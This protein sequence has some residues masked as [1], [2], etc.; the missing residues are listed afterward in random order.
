MQCH[1]SGFRSGD[2]CVDQLSYDVCKSFDANPSLKV[3]GIFLDMLKV[4]GRVWHEG[5]LFKLKRLVL[6]GKYYG[7]I[8][9]CLK[10]RQ[11]RVVLNGQSSKWSPIKAGVHQGFILGPLFF[12]AYIND[13]SKGLLSNPKLFADDTSTAKSVQIRSYFWSVFSSIRTECGDLPSKS[14]YSV[15]IQENTDQK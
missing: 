4:F 8:N 3:T 12:L 15:G 6:S 13:L 2:S 14:P 10:N 7:L 11:Q 9:S 5:L 1:Q